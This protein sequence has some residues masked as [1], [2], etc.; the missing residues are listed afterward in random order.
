MVR[1]DTLFFFF[2]ALITW[3]MGLA[4]LLGLA[5][6]VGSLVASLNRGSFLRG[7]RSVAS[8]VASIP[9]DLLGISPRRVIALTTLSVKESLRQRVLLVFVIFAAVFLFAGWFISPETQEPVKQ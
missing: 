1:E 3:V 6:V 7:V 9:G 4:T 2:P 8:F 5:L